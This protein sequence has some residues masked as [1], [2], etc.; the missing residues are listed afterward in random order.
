[1]YGLSSAKA[2]ANGWTFE[3]LMALKTVKGSDC[4]KLYTDGVKGQMKTPN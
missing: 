3:D 1:V 2:E 4:Y